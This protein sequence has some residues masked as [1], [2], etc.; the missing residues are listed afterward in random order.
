MVDEFLDGVKMNIPLRKSFEITGYTHEDGFAICT[1]CVK[2]QEIENL[3]PITLGS[4]WDSPPS[5]DRCHEMIEVNC[6]HT[7]ATWD[8]DEDDLVNYFDEDDVFLNVKLKC[9]CGSKETDIFKY[10]RVKDN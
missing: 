5:C 1:D 2:P 7:E 8:F 3:A 4:E 6:L 9:V 10:K